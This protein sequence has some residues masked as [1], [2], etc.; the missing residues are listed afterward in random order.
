MDV[1]DERYFLAALLQV[2]GI[3]RQKAAALITVFGN[4]RTVWEANSGDLF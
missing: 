4:A 3:G 1:K 2:A